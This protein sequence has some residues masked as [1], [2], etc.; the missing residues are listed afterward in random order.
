MR[1]KIK[2]IVR[3]WGDEP[4]TLF[5]HHIEIIAYVGKEKSERTIGIPVEQ[6]FEF[7]GPI[8]DALSAAFKTGRKDELTSIY[9]KLGVEGFRGFNKYLKGNSDGYSDTVKT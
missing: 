7:D 8:F 4:V 2:V 3:A 9:A 6:V 1:D 5:L